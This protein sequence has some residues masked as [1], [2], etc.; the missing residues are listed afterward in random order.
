MRISCD[1]KRGEGRS[2]RA[3][4]FLLVFLVEVSELKVAHV[5]CQLYSQEFEA[6]EA[7]VTE[8]CEAFVT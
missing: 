5:Y 1:Q 6:C 2:L 7:F 4:V 3:L 8:A